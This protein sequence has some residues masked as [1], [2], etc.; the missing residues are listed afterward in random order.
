MTIRK[1]M[2]SQSFFAPSPGK[3]WTSQSRGMRTSALAWPGPCK[4]QSQA[5][6]RSLNSAPS[7]NQ[8]SCGRAGSRLSNSPNSRAFVLPNAFGDAMSTSARSAIGVKTFRENVRDYRSYGFWLP[9]YQFIQPSQRLRPAMGFYRKVVSAVFGSAPVSSS[10]TLLAADGQ[11]R[12]GAPGF[13]LIALNRFI[14]S[15]R[16]GDDRRAACFLS[17]KSLFCF[18]ARWI[19]AAI[20]PRSRD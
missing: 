1:L 3:R 17:G 19:L 12:G 2:H 14:Y 8:Q 10:T 16:I 6:G 13:A 11:S 20:L 15:I 18:A 4:A 5:I 7:S 9:L